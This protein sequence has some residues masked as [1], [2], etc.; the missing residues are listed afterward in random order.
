M[1]IARAR[2]SCPRSIRTRSCC[3][4]LSGQSWKYDSPTL[5][6]SC[7]TRTRVSSPSWVGW[8]CLRSPMMSTSNPSLARRWVWALMPLLLLIVLV[9]VLVRFGPLGVFI[10]AFPPVEELTIDRVSLAPQMMAVHVTNGGPQPVTVAQVMVDEA[11]W[12][13]SM[14][15][16]HTVPRQ[17]YQRWIAVFLSLTAGLL[18]FL[19]VEAVHDALET[20]GT[21]PPAFQGVGLVLVGL[22]ITVLILV[23]VSRRVTSG[24]DAVQRRLAIAFLIALG[25]GLHNLG[26]GLAIGAAYSLG[27][28]ALGTF[29]VLGFTIHNTTDGLGIVAPIARDRPAVRTLA[30]LGILAGVPTILGSWIGGL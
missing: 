28:I 22:V 18:L 25:I 13:F 8:G 2:R 3:V 26:E 10:K 12:E 19:G 30:L 14:S 7:S 9:A 16:G 4:R 11:Y 20:A 27:K 15:P 29:L 6:A 23:A 5:A 17:L 21:L 24:A 1:C